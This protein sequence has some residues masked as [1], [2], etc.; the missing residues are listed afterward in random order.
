MTRQSNRDEMIRTDRHR[1]SFYVM[2]QRNVTAQKIAKKVMK[3]QASP[4]EAYKLEKLLARGAR[5]DWDANVMKAL[6]AQLDYLATQRKT[7]KG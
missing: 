7:S 4:D 3:L 5:L 6:R 2:K 1:E